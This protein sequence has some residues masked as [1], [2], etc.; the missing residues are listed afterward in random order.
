VS[1]GSNFRD[2][3]SNYYRAVTTRD[4]QSHAETTALVFMGMR[5]GCA[6][7]HKHPTE[8]WTL[9]D[10]LGMAAFFAKVKF[11]S[12]GEWKEEI[13]YVDP[14]AVLKHPK[15]KE[16]VKPKFPGGPVAEVLPGEDP[17]IAFAD[18]LIKPENPYFAKNL[19]N[20]ITYWLMGTGI[21]TEPDDLRPSNPPSN[22]KLLDYLVKELV[23]HKFDQRHIYRLILNSKTYQLAS[24][25]NSANEKDERLFSHRRVQ[26]L[27]AEQ[28]LD[29]ISQL[30]ESPETYTST[31]PEPYTR[32]S[33]LRAAQLSDGSIGNAF[34]EKFGRPTRDTPF[35]GDRSCAVSVGQ[36]MNLLNSR[37]IENKIANG[38]RIKRLIQ[39]NKTDAQI[40]EDMYLAALARFP[41]ESEKQT[42]FAYVAKDKKQRAALLGNVM[43]ALINTREFLFNH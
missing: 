19:V 38:T 31:I 16:I 35:E 27:G 41:T 9:D 25:P 43:W 12:T 6:R 26:R 42:I 7:C 33:N 18:W 30:T 15:T 4:P 40:V 20:R 34:L 14:D 32:I 3:P 17:R 37:D 10:D 1:S 22:P 23:T 24:K 2:G 28:L 13:V 8:N 5:M 21:V 36:A 39:E 29:A 11:K